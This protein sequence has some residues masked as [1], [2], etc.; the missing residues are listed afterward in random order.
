MNL[1][2]VNASWGGAGY[3]QALK[4]AIAAAGQKGLLFIAAAGN[5]GYEMDTIN[6]FPANYEL[7]NLISVAA[8]DRK[9][10]KA[11]FSNYGATK[12][13]IA[14]PGVDILSLGISNKGTTAPLASMSGTSMAAPHV[15]GAAGLIKAA[16]PTADY[17]AIKRRILHG[18]DVIKSLVSPTYAYDHYQPDHYPLDNPVVKGGRRLN[19]ASSLEADQ[20]APNAVTNLEISFSGVSTIEVMFNQAGDDGSVGKASGYVAAISTEPLTDLTTWEGRKII[21]LS[22]VTT[23]TE[24][25]LRAEIGGLDLLQSGYLTIRAV[26]NAGNM[27]PLSTSLKFE[28][29]KPN[30]NLLSSGDSYEGINSKEL[31][32]PT[33][34]W[35]QEEVAGR[36]KVWTDSPGGPRQV[37]AD[38][39]MEFTKPVTIDHP[40]AELQFD[41]KLD[42]DPMYERAYVDYLIN[43]EKDP[44][45]SYGVWNPDVGAYDWLQAPLWRSLVIYTA[46]KCE[47]ATVNLPL[48][49]KLKI[50]D[51]LRLRFWFRSFDVKEAERDGMLIDDI[52][53]LSPSTPSKPI[54]FA[55]TR[56][57]EQ[58]PFTLRWNDT[59]DGETRFEIYKFPSEGQPSLFA[60]TKTNVSIFEPGLT[61]LDQTLRVRACNG[62]LC[63][64]YSDPVQIMQPPPTISSISPTVTPLAG[65]N[66][67][68][69]NGSGFSVGVIARVHGMECPNL[70]RVSSSQLTC[71]PGPRTAGVYNVAVINPDQQRAALPASYTYRSAPVVS[72]VTPNK[73]RSRGSEVITLAGT[74]FAAGALIK[75]GQSACSGVVVKSATEAQ[76]TTPKINDGIYT[77]SLTNTEGQTGT[78]PQASAVKV[79]TPK[80]VA[81]NAGVC[82]NIC[83]AAGLASRLS[84]EGSY[85]T[86]GE[87]IPVS[88]VKQVQYRHGCWPFKDCRAQGVKSGIQVGKY[89]YGAGQKRD[90]SSS[91]IVMGCFCD[92]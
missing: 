33:T 12:V 59:S 8:V 77:V 4:D 78:T 46:A 76:C 53:I 28:T 43:E 82:S 42:C 25:V 61:T 58:T 34:P 66:T 40:D 57:N 72:T 50:G 84:P 83:S 26:D 18:A 35:L 29:S 9:D 32:F 90:N 92:L 88:A 81:T 41:A 13:H 75:L 67:L 71:T 22:Y 3:N 19:L 6:F 62:S 64:E 52:K 10:V 23:K 74:G 11:E 16:Y 17:A 37:G 1:P 14:A 36:G 2:V 69:I 79:I 21:D 73:I 49:S 15:T 80:W 39:Y 51:K 31:F 54:Q 48:R 91:D 85:C 89:C 47:W 55:A 45:S 70:K 87:H 56:P 65:G 44:T 24:G 20:V 5:N 30:V 27:G 7:D 86:S 60:E 63:S 68:T 38:A